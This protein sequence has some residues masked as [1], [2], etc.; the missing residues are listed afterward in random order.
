MFWG[1]KYASLHYFIVEFHVSM[2]LG[3]RP[4]KFSIEPQ[5]CEYCELDF[6]FGLYPR[7]EAPL[8]SF[9]QNLEA[10]IQD[11]IE[12]Q[13]CDLLSFNTGL[14]QGFKIQGSTQQF[15]SNL[16]SRPVSNFKCTMLK[17]NTG[18]LKPK[19]MT[20]MKNPRLQHSL[21]STV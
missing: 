12:L 9:P 6:N 3:F 15:P 13:H 21:H 16:G 4:E 20:K 14:D 18:F 5:Y 10:S 11:C 1:V 17:F 8:K 7:F 19:P 2:S